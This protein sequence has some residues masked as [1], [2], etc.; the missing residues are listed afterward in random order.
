MEQPDPYVLL[1]DD[2]DGGELYQ[3]YQSW[4]RSPSR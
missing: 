2:E 4:K 3:R 1:G